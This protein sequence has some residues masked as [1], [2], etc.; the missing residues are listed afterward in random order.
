MVINPQES[1][2]ESS[3]LPDITTLCS[4]FEN[5][6]LMSSQYSSPSPATRNAMLAVDTEEVAILEASLHPTTNHH[7]PSPKNQNMHHRQTHPPASGWKNICDYRRRSTVST[8]QAESPAPN[9][10]LFPHA[11]THSPK[12]TLKTHETSSA[13]LAA[14]PGKDSSTPRLAWRQPNSC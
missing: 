13:V 4:Q 11:P 14:S 12:T 9:H 7:R 8:D 6:S 3:P 10:F 2:M 5:L 1:T